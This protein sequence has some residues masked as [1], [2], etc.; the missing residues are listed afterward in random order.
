M[1]K[2]L[3]IRVAWNPTCATIDTFFTKNLPYFYRE[4][5]PVVSFFTVTQ[6]ATLF[7]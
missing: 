5:R 7:F 2:K 1:E 6:D 4:F 3:I